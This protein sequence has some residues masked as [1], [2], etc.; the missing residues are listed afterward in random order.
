MDIPKTTQIQIDSESELGKLLS[1]TLAYRLTVPVTDPVLAPSGSVPWFTFTGKPGE[2]A[3]AFVLSVQRIAFRQGRDRDD[4]WLADYA[5]TCFDDEALYWYLE[6]DEESKSSWRKLR[7]SLLSRYPATSANLTIHTATPSLFTGAPSGSRLITAPTGSTGRIEVVGH[8]T[9][10]L[11][12]L[13]FD[14]QLG[15]TITADQTQ[16]LRVTLPTA[17]SHPI[18][19][20]YM[21]AKINFSSGGLVCLTNTNLVDSFRATRMRRVY[22]PT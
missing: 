14:H 6:Q 15:A 3:S 10:P 20:I 4:A 5:S 11:G 2:S 16:A 21:V 13:S 7:S 1:P 17:Q 8:Y 22:F 12:Y 19:Q 9:E 18:L